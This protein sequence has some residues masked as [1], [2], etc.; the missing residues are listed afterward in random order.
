M[1]SENSSK[2]LNVQSNTI[3]VQLHFG[4]SEAEPLE[5]PH[6]RLK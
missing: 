2:I 5:E 1:I 3:R 6:E 4:L